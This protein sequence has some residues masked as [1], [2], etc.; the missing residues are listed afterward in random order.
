MADP[1]NSSHSQAE[2]RL[3][4]PGSLDQLTRMREWLR[5]VYAHAALEDEDGFN[6]LELAVAEAFTNIVR[7]AF[8]GLPDNFI[9]I[10]AESLPNLAVVT[11][12][13]FGD[14]FER[15]TAN[16]PDPG[17]AREGGF[18]LYIISR[19]VDEVSY[20]CNELGENTVRLVKT[21]RPIS[22]GECQDG[23]SRGENG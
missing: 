7:H 5:G 13:H 3:E 18:G 20:S 12:I 22:Q 23:A 6:L 15:C 8:H 17:A 16:P 19:A 11:L 21:L 1:M 14:R 10:R 9:R 2:A 4:L